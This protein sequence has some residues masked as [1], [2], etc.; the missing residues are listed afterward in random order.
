MAARPCVKSRDEGTVRNKAIYL[1][2]GCVATCW[3][4]RI[5]QT[6]SAKFWLQVAND[7]KLV[8]CRISRLPWWMVSRVSPRRSTPCFPRP[9]SGPASC[10]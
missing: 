3:A 5:E 10:T 1:A 2:L 6:E 8:E 7:L 4:Y 9:R